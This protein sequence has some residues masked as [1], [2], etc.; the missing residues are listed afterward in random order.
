M[1][2]AAPSPDRIPDLAI[3]IAKHRFADPMFVVVA[4]ASQDGIEVV[5]HSGWSH[6]GIFSQPV[7]NPLEEGFDLLLLRS[8]ET[9][10]LEVTNGE[11][12]K[13]T[14]FGQARSESFPNSVLT[15]PPST[16]LAVLE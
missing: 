7:S 5:N 1:S 16:S 9:L 10:V 12:Q 3:D 6:R 8:A 11:A 15:L 4:P 13:V 2:S 14:A